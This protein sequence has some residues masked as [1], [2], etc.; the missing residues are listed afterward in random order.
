MNQYELCIGE[1]LN[2]IIRMRKDGRIAQLVRAL[3][4][5]R[6]GLWFESRCDHKVLAG[7]ALHSFFLFLLDLE[8]FGKI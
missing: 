4:S 5:H 1:L 2:V 7:G 8:E 6:R 3:R